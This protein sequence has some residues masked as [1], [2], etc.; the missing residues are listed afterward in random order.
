MLN[1]G[2]V[3][4]TC[5]VRSLKGLRRTQFICIYSQTAV[6]GLML[7]RI[8]SWYADKNFQKIVAPVTL[9][10]ISVVEI[11]FLIDW[12]WINYF[13]INYFAVLVLYVTAKSHIFQPADLLVVIGTR[14]YKNARNTA[15]LST[16]RANK[17]GVVAGV[18]NTAA[19]CSGLQVCVWWNGNGRPY[20]CCP[21]ST[22]I[23]HLGEPREPFFPKVHLGEILEKSN[24]RSPPKW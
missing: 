23:V 21:C 7:T 12:C 20:V 24:S 17:G 16:F 13:L 4:G 15:T 2:G 11:Y 1:V 5:S 8:H 9:T 10:L 3:T 18:L 22:R 6:S 19:L 14:R